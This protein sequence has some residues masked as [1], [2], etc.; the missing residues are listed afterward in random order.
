MHV[1]NDVKLIFNGFIRP[2]AVIPQ[3]ILRTSK[4]EVR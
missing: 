2:E 4:G 3:F 1:L